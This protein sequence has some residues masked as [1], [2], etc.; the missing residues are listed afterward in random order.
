MADQK[1]ISALPLASEVKDGD[2]FVGVQE[3]VTKRTAVS[4][5]KSYVLEG[6][7]AG[8]VLSSDY[9]TIGDGL[10]DD[11]AALQAFWTYISNNSM[12]GV[13]PPGTYKI[14]SQVLTQLNTSFSIV[15]TG[16]TFV[17]AAGFP[18]AQGMFA[19]ANSLN[20]GHSFR[21][22]G[23]KFDGRNQPYTAVGSGSGCSM[24]TIN[25]SSCKSCHI[26]LERTYSGDD[27]LVSGSDTHVFVGGPSNVYVNID[28]AIGAPD[29]CVYISRNF[30][31]TIGEVAKVRGNY[32]R[33]MVGAI[34]K[35]QFETTDIDITVID[36]VT[37]GATG[38]ADTTTEEIASAG[39]GHT[40]KINAKRTE[41]PVF[42]NASSG[43]LVIVDA[44]QMGVVIADRPGVTGYTSP[45]VSAVQCRGAQNYFGILNVTGMNPLIAARS[46]D[47]AV[48]LGSI[49]LTAGAVESVKNYFMMKV[50][51]LGVPFI[52]SGAGTNDN[53]FEGKINDMLDAKPVVIGA[54]TKYEWYASNIKFRT[55]EERFLN[56][57]G[58]TLLAFNSDGSVG[59]GP[60][61]TGSTNP[62]YL[63][64]FSGTGTNR[65]A[66]DITTGGTGSADSGTRAI[67]AG[68]IN[69]IAPGI[70]FQG[71]P[72]PEA[73]NTRDSGEAAKRWANNFSRQYRPGAGAVIWTSGTGT[74]EGAVTA[75]AGSM[76]TR[77][78]GGAATT[79]YVK[80][81]GAGN[82]GWVAK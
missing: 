7:N 80:E 58:Q 9:G 2:V 65:T 62:A 61:G 69:L 10:A 23:G 67:Q 17:A 64:W 35:R 12:K 31:G 26:D 44:E 8:V 39:S 72:K 33:S 25:A 71:R 3:G 36:C 77:T 48:F 34:V 32:Y 57:A 68:Q 42:L 16:A 43:G 60:R 14:S 78:D 63:D 73:D 4:S 37:G 74:P 76:F 24:L 20:I 18:S 47:S 5:L 15:A 27:W 1:K 52:E 30:A 81:T 79:L 66:R 11:T 54:L 59:I 70:D 41:H 22:V 82:T 21:W 75:P 28:E 56:N 49:T 45:S 13:I 40:M 38:T 53:T 51:G 29:S 46:V 6:A 55:G 19:V 50:E